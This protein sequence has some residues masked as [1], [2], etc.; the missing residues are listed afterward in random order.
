[1]DTELAL[2]W[3][4]RGAFGGDADCCLHLAYIHEKEDSGHF[5]M[6]AAVFWMMEALRLRLHTPSLEFTTISQP[7]RAT[8]FL[9]CAPAPHALRLNSWLRSLVNQT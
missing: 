2:Y 9:S 1:M 3:F 5:D 8:N 7:R 4:R 6:P